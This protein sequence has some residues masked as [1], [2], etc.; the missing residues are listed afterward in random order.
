MQGRGVSKDVEGLKAR[1]LV[2]QMLC[3]F[4]VES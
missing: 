1:N 3:C 2:M 4:L